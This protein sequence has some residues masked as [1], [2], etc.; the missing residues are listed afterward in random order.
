M[1]KD[2]HTA[3]CRLC[4]DGA[5]FFTPCR[6]KQDL[7]RVDC[8]LVFCDTNWHCRLHRILQEEGEKADRYIIANGIYECDNCGSLCTLISWVTNRLRSSGITLKAPCYPYVCLYGYALP[9]TK[10]AYE[11]LSSGQAVIYSVLHLTRGVTILRA[12]VTMVG[13]RRAGAG[14]FHSSLAA[15]QHL[16]QL[17]PWLK[18]S[19]DTYK[20]CLLH[21]TFPPTQKPTSGRVKIWISRQRPELYLRT[22]W[23][24]CF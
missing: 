24:Q 4:V 14:G 22:R 7:V 11:F 16:A 10:P 5:I 17:T 1:S 19:S 13:R 20:S 6:N 9:S 12:D 3:E 15:L 21:L 23:R 8:H 18:G 2:C